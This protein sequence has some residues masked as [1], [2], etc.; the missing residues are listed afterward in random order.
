MKKRLLI[1]SILVVAILVIGLVLV[2]NP[3]GVFVFNHSPSM[4]TLQKPKIG[5]LFG[6][7]GYAAF[8]GEA[9]K[10]GFLL[11]I[12]DSNNFVDYSIE[13]T[14]SNVANAVTSATKLTQIDKVIA[15]IGPEWVEFGE[16]VIPVAQ[17]TSTV[18]ISPWMTL[19]LNWA[20]SKDYIS[21]TPSDRGMQKKMLELIQ[22]KGYSTIDVVYEDNSFAIA[23][24]DTFK[25]ELQ[26]TNLKLINEIKTTPN[27]KDFRTEITRLKNSSADCVFVVLAADSEQAD[28]DK[29]LKELGYTKSVFITFARAESDAFLESTGEASNGVYYYTKKE[30]ARAG[31]FNQKYLARFGKEPTALSAATAFDA[32]T[33]VIEAIKNGA[34][35]SSEIR[36]YLIN[37][38]NYEGYSGTIIFNSSGQRE[39][40]N[41]AVIKMISGKNST[42][43]Y[44]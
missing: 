25:E 3:T 30:S 27:Q 39:T 32:T 34:T 29:Q 17:K 5:G 10:N 31:E 15:V 16:V 33:L 20:K 40:A 19:E 26:K 35:S 44:E 2:Q 37:K 11:A 12:E 6:L 23:T 8:A 9:G 43:V 14:T 4:L 41:D 42:V 7:T 1:G 28:F 13:D 38:K 24:N 21:M 18:F 22:S 36:E